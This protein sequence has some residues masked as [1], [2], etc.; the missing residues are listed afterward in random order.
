MADSSQYYKLGLFVLA[1]I[2]FTTV[3]I[4]IFGARELFEEKIHLETYIDQSVQGLEIGSPV[5]TRGV[6]L[7]T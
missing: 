6:K 2:T 5:K 1:G 4:V 7:A 3:G